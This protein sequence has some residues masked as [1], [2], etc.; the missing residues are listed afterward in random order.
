MRAIQVGTL[1][2]PDQ[3]LESRRSWGKL[4]LTLAQ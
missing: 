1:G 3:F 4:V 2:G